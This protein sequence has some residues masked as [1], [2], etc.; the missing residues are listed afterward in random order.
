MPPEVLLW[1]GKFKT[2]TVNILLIYIKIII[3]IVKIY[4]GKVK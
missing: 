4:G 1:Y 2:N 3:P